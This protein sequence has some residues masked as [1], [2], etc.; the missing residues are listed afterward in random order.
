MNFSHLG[1]ALAA[2]NFPFLA[3]KYSHSKTTLLSSPK[4]RPTAFHRNHRPS[5]TET[6][7]WT[8]TWASSSESARHFEEYPKIFMERTG[9]RRGLVRQQ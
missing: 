6:G 7:D 3:K 4:W 8:M 2:R 1:D 9:L 5:T